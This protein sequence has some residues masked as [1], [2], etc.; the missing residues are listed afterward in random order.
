MQDEGEEISKAENPGIKPGLDAG[1]GGAKLKGDV[2]EGKVDA[3]GDKGRGD[4]K[5]G[6][7]NFKSS[8]RPGVVVEHYSS[9]VTYEGCQPWL[10]TEPAASWPTECF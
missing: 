10:S 1:E 8:G 3:G 4:D 6:D 7:L 5:A 2:F 9:D